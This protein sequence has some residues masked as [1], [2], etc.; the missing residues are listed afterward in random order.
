MIMCGSRTSHTRHASVVFRL[1][2]V[3]SNKGFRLKRK[4]CLSLQLPRR[5]WI[6]GLSLSNRLSAITFL[7]T[8]MA[9]KFVFTKHLL[10]FPCNDTL[11]LPRCITVSL[12]QKLLYT[13]VPLSVSGLL[14]DVG[15]LT[16]SSV[17]GPHI[18]ACVKFGNF[19]LLIHLMSIWWSDQISLKNLE[20]QGSL[21]LPS[22]DKL[23]ACSILINKQK[24]LFD[25]LLQNTFS[26]LVSIWKIDSDLQL[27][28]ALDGR[29]TTQLLN[30][31]HQ[32]ITGFSRTWQ[33]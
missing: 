33:L 19:L 14:W 21:F 10:F 27:A 12:A 1:L 26:K 16:L 31:E 29:R 9:G 15:S 13:S 28:K 3:K 30:T 18:Y 5:T 20:V 24:L 8:Y 7:P 22:S 2:W 11:K 32:A 17:Q 23:N 4:F 6:R 25:L